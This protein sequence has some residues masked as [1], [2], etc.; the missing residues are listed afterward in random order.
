M[1]ITEN[2]ITSLFK[3]VGHPD[4]VVEWKKGKDKLQNCEKHQVCASD[5]QFSDKIKNHTPQIQMSVDGDVFT[6]TID[7]ANRKDAGKYKISAVNV[8]GTSSQVVSV[9]VKDLS[10]YVFTF[11]TK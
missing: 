4:P 6:L 5:R 7:D 2:V 3:V 11:S 10:P 1:F 8:A 9:S